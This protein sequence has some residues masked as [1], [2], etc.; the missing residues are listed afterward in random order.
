VVE[1][2][3]NQRRRRD[4]FVENQSIKSASSIG[5]TGFILE[6]HS[7]KMSPLTGLESRR[8]WLDKRFGR[9]QSRKYEM[10]CRKPP[11]KTHARAG[12]QNLMAK[13]YGFSKL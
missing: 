6:W 12:Y 8:L 7:T 13:K 4:I 1:S 10:G 9:E 5:A 11:G 2:A 3:V